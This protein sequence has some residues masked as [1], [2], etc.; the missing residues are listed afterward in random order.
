MPTLISLKKSTEKKKSLGSKLTMSVWA[1][2][3]IVIIRQM[4]CYSF[5]DKALS[6]EVFPATLAE[7]YT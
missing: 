3:M 4:G 5:L 2:T 7:I 1:V 6:I